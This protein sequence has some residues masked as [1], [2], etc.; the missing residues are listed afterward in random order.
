MRSTVEGDGP[1]EETPLEQ[2]ALAITSGAVR[3]AAATATWLRLVAEF[4]ERGGW[5]G[6]GI[7]SCAHWL[8]WQC[9][10][11]P[12]AAREHVRVARA[13]R[14]LPRIEAVFAAGRLSYSKVRALTRVAEPD[15]E[16]ALLEFAFAATA[17]QTERF[18]REWRRVDETAANGGRP[19]EREQFFEPRFEDGWFTLRVRMP[20]EQGAAFMTAV[21]ALAE[22][23]ARR[24]RAQG[25]KAAAAHEAIRAA[26][27]TVDA[28][29]ERRCA[30]DAAIGMVRERTAARRIAAVTA[31]AEARAA[32]DRR[33]GDPPRREVVVHVDAD[34][35]A[36]DTAAGRAHFEGGPALTGA[37]ARRLLCGATVVAMIERGREPL[38][39]GRRKRR[40]TGAQRRALLRREGGCARPGCPET[41]PERL[42]VHHMH[43]WLFGG[44]T[45]VADMVLLCDVD[46]GLVH[47]RG[48]VMSRQEGRLVVTTPDGQR[49]WGTADAAFTGGLHGAPPDPARGDDPYAG[50]APIDTTVGRRPADAP[51]PVPAP[52]TRRGPGASSRRR[53]SPARPERGAGP[54]SSR[55]GR[56]RHRPGR[57]PGHGRVGASPATTRSRLPLPTATARLD[58]VLFPDGP[59]DLPAAAPAPYERLDMHWAIGVLMGNRDLLRQLEAEGRSPLDG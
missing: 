35:L 50:V 1:V 2:L 10:M 38:A 4:D 51:T 7:L 8:A 25:K 28:E 36:D 12:G 3:L 17:S 58:R 21:D 22:R 30:E 11:G 13:L 52:L 37:Q 40:A 39:V 20:A 27:G 19:V 24:E 41:R 46:H 49:V 56:G 9:G 18:C 59:P 34:V 29:V 42:H 5:H 55:S 32:L 26:G 16:A 48:L 53:R 15:S 31:L 54:T 6:V 14:G 23:E 45:D 33:P 44:R 57:S 43:H 47:E